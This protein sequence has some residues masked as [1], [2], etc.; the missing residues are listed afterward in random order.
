MFY[1]QCQEDATCAGSFGLCFYERSTIV[2]CD[3]NKEASNRFW[4]PKP[5]DLITEPNLVGQT[6]RWAATDTEEM[7]CY[8]ATLQVE[9]LDGRTALINNP[10][11][12]KRIFV[13]DPGE[14]P[15]LINKKVIDLYA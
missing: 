4:T 8:Y 13:A 1:G 11:L 3:E 6:W 15:Y 5:E 7:P 14:P 2:E 10:L 9:T 12:S